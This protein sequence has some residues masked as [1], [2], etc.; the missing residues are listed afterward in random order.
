[1]I[2]M[3]FEGDAFLP[4]CAATMLYLLRDG[5]VWAM[6]RVWSMMSEYYS[7]C[8]RETHFGRISRCTF[9]A[10]VNVVPCMLMVQQHQKAQDILTT[11]HVLGSDAE[12]AKEAVWASLE[13]TIVWPPSKTDDGREVVCL[14]EACYLFTLE[15][16]KWQATM[17]TSAESSSV[18]MKDAPEWLPSMDSLLTFDE[19][20]FFDGATTCPR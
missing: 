16:V 18:T 13:S 10:V 17:G 3:S 15:A 20:L 5:N 8:P 7:A 6:N 4:S 9:L 19:E 14:T 11:L 2:A 12:E 1:M